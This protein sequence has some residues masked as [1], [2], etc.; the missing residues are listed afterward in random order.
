MPSL[1]RLTIVAGL[2]FMLTQPIPLEARVLHV[3]AK[4]PEASDEN[5]ATRD[6]PLATISKAAF[7][8]E[9]GDTVR[10]YAGVYRERVAPRRGGTAKAAITYEAAAGERVTIKASEAWSPNW[11]KVTGHPTLRRAALEPSWF[12]V[13]QRQ[14][15]DWGEGFPKRYNPFD[16]PLSYPPQTRGDSVDPY[17]QVV[18]EGEGERITRGQLFLNGVPMRQVGTLAE[19]AAVPGSWLAE[20]G[21]ESLIV[22]LPE[23]YDR[24]GEP[25]FEVTVR[26][27]CFAPYRRGLSHITVRGF[28]M[29]HGA[30]DYHR[31]FYADRS[32]Q[33]GI[34]STR[35]GTHWTIEHNVIRFGKTLGI[36]IGTEGDADADGLDQPEPNLAGQ[37]VIRFNTI[38][39]HGAGGIQGI[40]SHGTVI[41]HNV[42]ERNNR[43]GFT[44]PEVG[45]I[46]LHFFVDGR[47]ENNLIRGNDCFGVWLDN[48]YHRA[49]VR[50]NLI[51]NNAGAGIFMEMGHGPA[52]IDHN[53]IALTRFGPVSGMGDGLYAHDASGV[54]FVHNLVYFNAGHGLYAHLATDRRA[55]VYRDGAFT[56]DRRACAASDW[57][58]TGNFFLGNS[59]GSLALPP[60]TP[61]SANNHSDHNAFA[62]PL[63]PLVSETWAASL[64]DTDFR[65]LT[66]KG[67][68]D[69]A[70][71]IPEE[72]LAGYR[73]R[74]VLGLDAWRELTDNDHH[75]RH[76]LVLRPSLNPETLLLSL[77]VGPGF[78]LVDVPSL[79]GINADIYH[80]PLGETARP[81]P[82]QSLVSDPRLADPPG[83]PIPGRGRFNKINND[84]RNLFPLASHLESAY[85]TNPNTD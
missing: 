37:H 70:E 62:G 51:L 29:E 26:A 54:N 22:N 35:G 30:T 36:D 23:G 32:P 25:S 84:Y 21:G 64:G 19:A 52:T 15:V 8:A 77:I 42:I 59:M 66:N 13:D 47:I 1:Q 73:E 31:G 28:V 65:V 72:D 6:A 44:S 67:R 17:G 12:D 16:Q 3:D 60:D 9:P 63:P 57:R 43:L 50:R 71:V 56:G 39:D 40:R 46:K 55:A 48:V 18:A 75:S 14:A 80:T 41:K 69:L 45:A 49:V 78:D 85:Q 82:F 61:M 81:G 74:P 76:V 79:A 24:H 10:V 7:L 5:D 4:H 38:T 34:L 2:F 11:E 53:I 58:I 33:A 20:P 68:I 83:E 27:R